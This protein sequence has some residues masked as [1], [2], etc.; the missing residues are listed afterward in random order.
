MGRRNTG[1]TQEQ[2][3]IM[4]RRAG[5]RCELCNSPRPAHFHHRKPRRMGGVHGDEF[6]IVNAVPNGLVLCLGCHTKVESNRE[7]AK[8]R[9]LLLK[10]NQQPAEEPVHLPRYGGWVTLGEKG[11]IQW[12]INSTPL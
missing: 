12:T 9:G 3:H 5:E 2:K 1:F 7:W 6:E 11:E 4:L 10:M 8:H